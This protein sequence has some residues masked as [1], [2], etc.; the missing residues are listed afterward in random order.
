MGELTQ[1]AKTGRIVYTV[2]DDNT[3][4]SWLHWT[5]AFLCTWHTDTDTL[6]QWHNV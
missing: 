3:H 4:L 2:N 6:R 1:L 5:R